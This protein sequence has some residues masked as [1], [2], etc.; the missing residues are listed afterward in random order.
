LDYKYAGGKL[1]EKDAATAIVGG[2]RNA[3]LTNFGDTA[4][5]AAISILRVRE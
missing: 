1:L 4:S 3:R 5:G 2:S